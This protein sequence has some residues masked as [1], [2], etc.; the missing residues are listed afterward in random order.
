MYNNLEWIIKER[1]PEKE[2]CEQ[3]SDQVCINL[4]PVTQTL[5]F[6]MG[7]IPFCLTLERLF[8]LFF[9]W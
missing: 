4:S 6:F 5:V 3:R 8:E 2:R 9:E 1:F 7:Q